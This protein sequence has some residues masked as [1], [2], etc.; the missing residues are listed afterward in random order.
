MVGSC[1]G[2]YCKNLFLGF[3]LD[4]T[5]YMTLSACPLAHKRSML[6]L[7]LEAANASLIEIEADEASQDLEFRGTL[8]QGKTPRPVH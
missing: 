3:S 8:K 2:N 5:R 6:S 1:M 4:F 7:R